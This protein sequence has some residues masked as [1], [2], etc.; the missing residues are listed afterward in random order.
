MSNVLQ[1][2]TSMFP[3]KEPK[4][5]KD[6]A[7]PQPMEMFAEWE[8]TDWKHVMYNQ[9]VLS[10]NYPE[11]QTLIHPCDISHQGN[12]HLGFVINCD[13]DYKM[14]L[15]EL[16][17]IYNKQRSLKHS[18][19]KPN[20]RED[21]TNYYYKCVTQLMS[22]YF[23]RIGQ[24]TYIYEE[25]PL[26]VAGESIQDARVRLATLGTKQRCSKRKKTSETSSEEE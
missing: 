26:F 22:K 17:A 24:G 9:M 10:Y 21:L 16:F 12:Y 3:S 8:L 14:E 25:M 15:A 19:L 13:I 4:I 18:N 2:M 5:I 1:Q 6:E 23:T 11:R 7:S 20:Y